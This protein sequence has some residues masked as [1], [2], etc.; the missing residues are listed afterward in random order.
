MIVASGLGRYLWTEAVHHS[1]WL[2]TRIP[3]HA[4][5][6]FTILIDK[7]MGCKPNLRGILEWGVLVWV[8][9]LQARKFNLRA[10]EG[11]FVGYDEESKACHV[12]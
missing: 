10:K 5:P 4:S 2:S 7:V 12:Y 1:V 9:D 11:C 6:D 3:S 8:K